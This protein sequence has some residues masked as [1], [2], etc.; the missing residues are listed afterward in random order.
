MKKL[1]LG[2]LLCSTT[3]T[4][5]TV[6]QGYT[7]LK[8]TESYTPI[9]GGASLK[10]SGV[11]TI[12]PGFDVT[13][14]GVKSSDI[15]V[16]TGV[17]GTKIPTQFKGFYADL[18]DGTSTY[19]VTGSAGNRIV[20]LQFTGIKFAHISWEPDYVTFQIWIYEKDN[21]LELH[22][23]PSTITQPDLGYYYQLGGP[24]IGF[25]GMWLKGNES[26]PTTDTSSNTYLTGTPASG[27]VYR[28]APTA[29]GIGTTT[30]E[31]DNISLY[32]NP[33]NGIITI[34]IDKNDDKSYAI[35]YDIT[36]R[37]IQRQKLTNRTN[38][39]DISQLQAGSYI[40][41]ISNDDGIQ[42]AFKYVKQ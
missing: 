29:A 14:D 11:D 9:T 18:Q 25:K 10:T 36:Q 15:Y 32:P 41:N 3:A 19:K 5:K 12:S 6:A 7:F 22:M 39:I 27:N 31:K 8:K 2:I 23:G 37:E 17:V 35:V 21:A 38:R 26:N 34:D 4:L 30:G 28:F 1:L 16:A 33:G 13:I 42:R 40:I 24:A 20:K